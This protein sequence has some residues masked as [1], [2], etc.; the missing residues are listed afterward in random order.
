MSNEMSEK[1][2]QY[3]MDIAERTALMSQAKRL[4]VGG[5]AVK[6]RRIISSG[7]NG[8]PEGWDNTCEDEYNGQLFTRAEVIHAEEN[9]ICQLASGTESAKGADLFLTHS[10]CRAC[11]KL[12]A[13]IGFKNVYFREAYR[14]P[15]A[16]NTL[17][18]YGV[19]VVH[20]DV[21]G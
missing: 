20:V 11:S 2:I 18:Q 3:F 9:I 8:T 12:I 17:A 15:T 16:I 21:Q 1:Y 14:D 19:N 10:P 5:V 7:W 4:K 6:N 13:Q